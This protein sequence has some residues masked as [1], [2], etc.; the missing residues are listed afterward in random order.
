[1][2]KFIL[3]IVCFFPLISHA[4]LK[5][6]DQQ[7][8]TLSC[9]DTNQLVEILTKEYKEFA[10]IIGDT[11]DLAKSVMSLWVG[12][13]GETWTIVATKDEISCIVGAG[14]NLRVIRHGQVI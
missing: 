11:E 14:K 7:N 5:L 1:M 8:V 4:Q 3:W 9:Y 6:L 10:F 12:R 2:R 13:K